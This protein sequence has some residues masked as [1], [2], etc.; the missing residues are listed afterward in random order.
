MAAIPFPGGQLFQIHGSKLKLDP[1]CDAGQASV[2]GITH[3]VFFFCVGKDPFNGLFPP[4]VQ[5]PVF[6]RIADVVGQF[7]VV[8][9]DMPLYG[10]YTVPG[11]G[12]QMAGGTTGADFGVA[13][14]F[15]VS[16]PV[17]RAV[18]Q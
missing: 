5:L 2:V 1:S 16:V 3:G 13:F 7:L 9:P 11:A 10:L 18:G 4:L 12:T 14:V 8:P 17:G 6:G 15:P